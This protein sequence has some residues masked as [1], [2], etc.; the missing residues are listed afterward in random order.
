MKLWF[1]LE[2][3]RPRLFHDSAAGVRISL[4]ET[5]HLVKVDVLIERILES[6]SHILRMIMIGMTVAML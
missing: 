6:R 5:R 2:S 3:L 4:I 1:S